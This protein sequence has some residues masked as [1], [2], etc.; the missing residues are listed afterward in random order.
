MVL[1]LVFKLW[2]ASRDGA[3]GVVRM[4][5]QENRVNPNAVYKV[6]SLVGSHSV[7]SKI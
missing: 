2:N 5:L 4:L 6:K 7:C 3:S 1:C